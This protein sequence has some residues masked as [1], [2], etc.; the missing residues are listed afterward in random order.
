MNHVDKYY[1]IIDHPKWADLGQATIELTPQMVNPENET[2]ETKDTRRHLN[3]ANRWW[4]EVMYP[5]LH[6][7][8]VVHSCHDWKLDTGG[9]SAE[10]A[11]DSLYE[12]VLKHYGDYDYE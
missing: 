7:G 6:E 4:V 3:T 2:I 11:I 12:L 9:D 1:W 10:S 8:E 5:E